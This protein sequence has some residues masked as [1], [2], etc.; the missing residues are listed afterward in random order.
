MFIGWLGCSFHL[1]DSHTRHVVTAKESELKSC[2][3][4][5]PPVSQ[6]STSPYDTSTLKMD[7]ASS[8]EELVSTHKT[9][10]GYNLWS[11]AML[12]PRTEAR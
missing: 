4:R 7:A 8:P 1:T 12:S 5:W 3:M 2:N 11:H 10:R 9:M 6:T